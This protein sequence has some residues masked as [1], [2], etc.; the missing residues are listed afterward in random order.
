MNRGEREKRRAELTELTF[1]EKGYNVTFAVLLGNLRKKRL[2]KGYCNF[3]KVTN[4]AAG[5]D[6]RRLFNRSVRGKQSRGEK[7]QSE[8]N[9]RIL[10]FET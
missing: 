2:R 7:P 6:E 9:C 10:I 3:L 1:P 4:L 8:F 5:V